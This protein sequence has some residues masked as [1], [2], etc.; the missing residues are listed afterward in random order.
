MTYP[1]YVL[2]GTAAQAGNFMRESGLMPSQVRY[3]AS[4]DHVRGLSNPTYWIVGT[5]WDRSDAIR[6]W[7]NLKRCMVDGRPMLAP[8]HIE[9]FL[10]EQR[11]PKVAKD[12]CGKCGTIKPINEF[13]PNMCH[14]VKPVVMPVAPDKPVKFK[15]IKDVPKPKPEKPKFKHIKP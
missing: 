5:F 12:T 11:K 15:H 4:E 10:E 13:C 2:A 9:Q 3:V 6:I 1:I 14:A 7:E 8:P